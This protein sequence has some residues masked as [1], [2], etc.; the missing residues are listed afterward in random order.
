MSQRKAPEVTEQDHVQGSATAEVTLIEYGDFECPFCGAAYPIL[1]RVRERLGDKL[2]FVFRNFPIS[3]SHRHAAHAAEAA[4]S[5]ADRG[6][7][8]AFWAMHDLLFEHQS[9]LD[10]ASL[11]RYATR[12]GVDG[13]LVLEDLREERYS[14]RVNQSFLGGARSGVNGTPTLFIDGIRYDGPRDEE[15]LVEALQAFHTRLP[16]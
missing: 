11:A 1:K 6:G 3:E 16:S 4:E 5:V 15:A 2:R 7:P 13:E 8:A 14:E 12:A 10:D 9:A